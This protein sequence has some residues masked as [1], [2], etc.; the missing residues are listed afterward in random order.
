MTDYEKYCKSY[1][2]LIDYD[3]GS[4]ESASLIEEWLNHTSHEEY[5][6]KAY[7]YF[8]RMMKEFFS[9]TPED[10]M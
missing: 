2:S 10:L 5:N 6:D 4:R 8:D 7:D 9:M 3:D 1:F